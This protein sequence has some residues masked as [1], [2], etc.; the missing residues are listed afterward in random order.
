ML[1]KE[2]YQAPVAQ[3]IMAME[4]CSVLTISDYDGNGIEDPIDYGTWN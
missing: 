3:V 2:S 1:E 4:A